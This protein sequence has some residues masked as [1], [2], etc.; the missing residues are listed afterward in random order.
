M[1]LEVWL[2]VSLG[3]LLVETT[4]HVLGS[5]GVL[6]LTERLI[7]GRV[8]TLIVLLWFFGTFIANR[9]YR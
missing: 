9:R 5:N 8:M 1:Q 6:A 7:T 4:I 2:F 3:A